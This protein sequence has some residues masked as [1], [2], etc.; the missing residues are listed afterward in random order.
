MNTGFQIKEAEIQVGNTY[1]L[2]GMIT[3]FISDTPGC[4]VIEINYSIQ[5][6]IHIK[7]SKY[8]ELLKRRAFEPA[9]FV[10]EIKSKSPTIVDCT[11]IVFGKP[12]HNLPT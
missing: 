6:H 4:M 1:C 5:A 9:V 3:K 2:Y 10:S 7:D 8:I 12:Q 11:T